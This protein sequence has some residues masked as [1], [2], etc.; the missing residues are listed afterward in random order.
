IVQRAREEIQR[1]RESALRE[2]RGEVAGMVVQASEQILGRSIDRDEHER[3]IS[4]ALDELETEV[5]GA[6][7]GDGR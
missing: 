6:G 3:L 1:E 5:A 7:A 2:V 4:E